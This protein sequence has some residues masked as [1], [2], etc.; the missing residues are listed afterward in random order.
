M[1]HPLIIHPLVT[2]VND[3]PSH[4]TPSQHTHPS[5]SLNTLSHNIPH[6]HPISA[7]EVQQCIT[8]GP[9]RKTV[10]NEFKLEPKFA[11]KEE[12][13]TGEGFETIQNEVHENHT[14][15]QGLKVTPG[16]GDGDGGG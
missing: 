7:Y 14:V 3:N 13:E 10:Q 2:P 11:V 8:T 5:P 12:M 4:T 1:T 6:P 15:V 16:D 9:V